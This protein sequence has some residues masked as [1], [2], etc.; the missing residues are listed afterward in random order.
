M[1]LLFIMT[2]I[3]ISTFPVA[4]GAIGWICWMVHFVGSG[5]LIWSASRTIWILW[6]IF[7]VYM[8]IVSFN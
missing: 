8:L 1:I 6:I 7:T 2:S 5:F 4:L 3:L